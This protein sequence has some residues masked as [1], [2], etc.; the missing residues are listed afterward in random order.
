MML[1]V[2]LTLA[3]VALLTIFL[4]DRTIA[5]TTRHGAAMHKLT[6]ALDAVS[7]ALLIMLSLVTFW[8]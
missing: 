8:S 6:R 5:F 4:R 1:G 3:T 2:L 7:G